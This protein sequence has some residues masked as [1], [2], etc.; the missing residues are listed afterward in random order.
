MCLILQVQLAAHSYNDSPGKRKGT[1]STR[2]KSKW[3]VS[4]VLSLMTKTY[5]RKFN[6]WIR[7]LNQQCWQNQ[8]IHVYLQ[9]WQHIS[10]A[11]RRIGMSV[12][13]IITMPQKEP[14]NL[15]QHSATMRWVNPEQ[16]ANK[17]TH[18]T[19]NH[20]H[21]LLPECSTTN[22]ACRIRGCGTNPEQQTKKQQL[23]F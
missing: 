2:V 20:S 23:R 12:G 19:G 9:K 14:G 17:H 11:R 10:V 13:H 18:E 7:H 4:W 22:L 21:T 16:V 5:K 1:E 8:K 3:K 15:S 6:I